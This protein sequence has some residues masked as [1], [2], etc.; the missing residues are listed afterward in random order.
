M[1]LADARPGM[2]VVYTPLPG[3]SERE[4]GVITSVGKVVVFVR[5]A[6]AAPRSHGKACSPRDLEL[7]H[8]G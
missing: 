6:G 5:F 3:S 1:K 7:A 4:Y 8:Q 2:I